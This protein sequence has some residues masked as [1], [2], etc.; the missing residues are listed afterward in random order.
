MAVRMM[1]TNSCNSTKIMAN[2]K[3][4]FISFD[5]DDS[6][7]RYLL[8]AWDANDVFDFE[9]YDGSLSVA[10]NSTNANYIKSV[11]KPKIQRSTHLLCLVGEKTYNSDWVTWEINKAVEFEKKIIAV[12]IKS[13][14]TT[15]MALY[16]VGASWA[17]SFTFD[18]IKKAVEAT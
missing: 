2:K 10:V 1:S 12:K 3:R 4:V 8:V 7:Y 18:A 9:F 5:Y 17:M 11:I 15:P 13:T 14:Y 16:G 6:H